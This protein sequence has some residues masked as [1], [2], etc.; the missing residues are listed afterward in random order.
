MKKRFHN[1]HCQVHE[2]MRA[3]KDNMA[4]QKKLDKITAERAARKP[5]FI[6]RQSMKYVW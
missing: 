1:L 2:Q 5:A 6:R 3:E 4:L